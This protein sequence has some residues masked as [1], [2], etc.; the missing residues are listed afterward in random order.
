MK[1]AVE[2][3]TLLRGIHRLW[4]FVSVAV[5]VGGALGYLVSLPMPK[6]YEA[7]T[8][9]LVGEMRRWTSIQ[10]D[11]LKAS[12]SMAVTYGD[13]VR[14]Q[15]VLEG[16]IKTLDLPTTWLEVRERVAVNLAE[17]NPQLIVITVDAG[18]PREA[19]AIAREIGRQ[20]LALSPNANTTQTHAFV[21]GQLTALQQKIEEDQ[22]RVAELRSE[23]TKTRSE[24]LRT[25]IDE[26]EQMI[27]AWQDNYA[28]LSELMPNG[29]AMT[30]LEILDEAYASPH[31]VR[32]R[33]H[34]NALLGAAIAGLLAVAIVYVDEQRRR[35]IRLPVTWRVDIEQWVRRHLRRGNSD[36]SPVDGLDHTA[37]QVKVGTPEHVS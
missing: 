14:R 6:V 34:V 26:L 7:T 9:V 16:V 10:V 15:P 8:T 17:N 37:P 20:L 18:S 12:Q 24:V 22:A 27:D 36:S 23:L 32:P 31:P 33:P 29:G 35:G 3:N 25:R 4:W 13:I 19:E 1:D 21:L 2:L 28:A 30:S 5:L 11:D